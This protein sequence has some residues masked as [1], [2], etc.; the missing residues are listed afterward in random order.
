VRESK[1]ASFAQPGRTGNFISSQV[2][3]MKDEKTV[4][5]DVKVVGSKRTRTCL[6]ADLA[7]SI[8]ADGVYADVWA[9]EP[10]Q[11]PAGVKGRAMRLKIRLLTGAGPVPIY[12]DVALIAN[13]RVES[14]LFA[15]TTGRIMDPDL[16][17]SL[18]T[19]LHT[20]AK[21]IA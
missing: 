13:R 10:V 19:T 4:A 15:F 17:K 16:Q 18:F 12:V 6:A 5:N 8:R 3:L 1:E 9:T 20:R 21:A 14:V 7:R 2:L 11:L